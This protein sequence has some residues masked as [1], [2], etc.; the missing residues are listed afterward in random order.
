MFSDRAQA[1]DIAN[2]NAE[3]VARVGVTRYMLEEE[4]QEM[5]LIRT[6]VM[7]EGPISTPK[8]CI[9]L[10]HENKLKEEY[11]KIRQFTLRS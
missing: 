7:K 5:R 8:P 1:A 9:A 10:N 6:E 4:T 3:K 2:A 11:A